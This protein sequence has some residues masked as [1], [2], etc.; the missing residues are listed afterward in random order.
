MPFCAVAHLSGRST[1][2]DCQAKNRGQKVAQNDYILL[3][4]RSYSIVLAIVPPR[5]PGTYTSLLSQHQS[6]N[7]DRDSASRP[8]SRPGGARPRGQ[9]G[10]RL[11]LTRSDNMLRAT[12]LVALSWVALA[13]AHTQITY[14]GERRNNLHSNGTLPQHDPSNIGINYVDGQYTF[15]YGM[16]WMYPC[17][18]LW[19]QG[20]TFR[21][22]EG[23]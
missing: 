8:P 10:E 6:D 15:P 13:C 7:P 1:G 11:S 19:R 12:L 17:K 23:C 18:L 14:P 16:Q 4:L 22:R 2:V 5:I 3:S 20:E 21:D 9:W